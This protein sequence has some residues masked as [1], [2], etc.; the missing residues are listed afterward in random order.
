[1]RVGLLSDMGLRKSCSSFKTALRLY[2]L[3]P[4]NARIA[5][6]DTVLPTGGG[7]MGNAPVFRRARVHVLHEQLRPSPRQGYL[8]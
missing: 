8:G 3:V 1:M 4:T 2:P 5:L 7:P 6:K